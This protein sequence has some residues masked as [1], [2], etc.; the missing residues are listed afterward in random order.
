MLEYSGQL[1][2]SG[3]W[4]RV[5]VKLFVV[6]IKLMIMLPG[7]SEWFG[8]EKQGRDHGVKNNSDLLVRVA[9]LSFILER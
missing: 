6:F 3:K 8:Q 9:S 5:E 7:I 1:Y 4:V 2:T